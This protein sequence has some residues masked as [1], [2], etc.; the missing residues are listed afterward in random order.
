MDLPQ[1]LMSAVE[2]GASD[3]HLKLGRTP[4]V[5]RD[6][7]ILELEGWPTLSADDLQ[8]M[9]NTLTESRPERRESFRE[10]GELDIGYETSGVRFRANAFRQRGA[11]SIVVRIIPRE[12]PTLAGLAMPAGVTRLANERRGL[13]L[14]TGATGSGK[15]TTLAAMVDHINTTRSA[16]IITIEDPIE[17][18]F[19]DRNCIINQREVGLDTAS[20]TQALR[21]ALRQDPDVIL[22]GEL[23]DPET[24]ET[25]LQ[26]AESGHLVLATMHTL[27]AAETVGRLSEFFPAAKQPMIRAIMAA[28]LRGVISHRLLPKVDGGRTPAVEV[29][30]VNDRIADL[31]RENRPDELPGAM[32]DREYY[33]MRTLPQALI[34]L[35]LAGAIDRETAAGAA[36]NR[37]DFLLLLQHAE[38]ARAAAAAEVT[39]S[40][41]STAEGPPGGETALVGDLAGAG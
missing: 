16:H 33:D 10:T 12:V 17:M 35:A 25:A 34:E 38:K 26:A 5:R 13:I 24:A 15:S 11:V 2:S 7:V 39:S 8:G 22:I 37:H 31:I 32:K 29:M 4:V 36:P 3:L 19:T 6:G 40:A 41:S 27:D 28:V 30:V 20:F 9:V 18:L 21:R 1:L 14:V 23:R